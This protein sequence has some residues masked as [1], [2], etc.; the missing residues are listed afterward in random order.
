[1]ISLKD[2]SVGQEV[3]AGDARNR[4][5]HLIQRVEANYMIVC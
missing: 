3:D 1:M 2:D 4:A 5:A